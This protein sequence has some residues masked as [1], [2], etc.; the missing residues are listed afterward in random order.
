MESSLDLFGQSVDSVVPQWMYEDF[1]RKSEY[2]KLIEESKGDVIVDMNADSSGFN[3]II[4]KLC[5]VM[6]Y[7][8]KTEIWE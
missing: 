3:D 6:P 5:Q 7:S 8:A 4:N 1:E 2:F